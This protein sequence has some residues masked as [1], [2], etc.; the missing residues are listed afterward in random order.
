MTYMRT[1]LFL[2]CSAQHNAAVTF[3][4]ISP[5]RHRAHTVSILTLSAVFFLSSRIKAG[6]A[7]FASFPIPLKR[8]AA[9]RGR[10]IELDGDGRCCRSGEGNLGQSHSR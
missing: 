3:V 5:S 1:T 9:V 6:T 10:F 8:N 4:S 2:S 7:G